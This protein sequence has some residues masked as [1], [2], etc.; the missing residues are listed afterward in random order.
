M[1]RRDLIINVALLAA[2][3]VLGSLVAMSGLR[4]PDVLPTGGGS[5]A[6]GGSDRATSGTLALAPGETQ[7]RATPAAREEPPTLPPKIENDRFAQLGSRNIF[8]TIIDKPPPPKTPTPTPIPYPP[9]SEVVGRWQLQSL[10]VGRASFL[11]ADTQETFDLTVGGPPHPKTY[12][13]FAYSITL[14]RVDTE[15][16]QAEVK[17]DHG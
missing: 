2:I 16:Y 3:L 11:D 5:A 12:K 1:R 10:D 14:V 15:N 8:K 7:Y 17:G 6:P 9:I 13:T 4:Q